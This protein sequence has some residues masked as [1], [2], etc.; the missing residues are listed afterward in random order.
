MAALSLNA[1]GVYRPLRGLMRLTG[2]SFLR[3]EELSS[4]I[5]RLRQ[6]FSPR[7][8][9]T[10]PN[11]VALPSLLAPLFEL[12][13]SIVLAVPKKKV[14]HSRKSMRSANKG[15]K[16]KLSELQLHTVDEGQLWGVRVS[17]SI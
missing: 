7:I 14:S 4:T 9:F 11:S 16:E 5:P 12:F 1:S 17:L 3:Q 10:W 15:L 13:P 6:L 2:A 8:A